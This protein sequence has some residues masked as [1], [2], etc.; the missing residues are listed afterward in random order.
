MSKGNGKGKNRGRRNRRSAKHKATEER[1][2]AALRQIGAGDRQEARDARTARQQ[3]AELDRRLGAGR[4][5][6]KERFKLLDIIS[7]GKAA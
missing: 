2:G 5:A 6:V 1:L 7:R 3:L 4:G